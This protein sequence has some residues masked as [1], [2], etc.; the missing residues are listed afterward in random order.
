M[1]SVNTTA[2]HNSTSQCMY[3]GVN[4]EHTF[5]LRTR[6]HAWLVNSIWLSGNN[7]A[8]N[9][10]ICSIISC[11]GQSWIGLLSWVYRPHCT[12]ILSRSIN[13]DSLKKYP[14]FILAW[15]AGDV[16][17][18]FSAYPV[19]QVETAFVLVYGRAPTVWVQLEVLF[20]RCLLIQSGDG[21]EMMEP[22]VIAEQVVMGLRIGKI[23]SVVLVSTSIAI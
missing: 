23:Q 10:L 1:V 7:V 4:M 2:R 6:E 13:G 5:A 16:S 14:T 3:N 11:T 15:R 9:A 18:P 19:K 17:P 22:V 12:V 8:T 21:L 20:Q